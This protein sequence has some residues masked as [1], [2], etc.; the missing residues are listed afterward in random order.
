[1][2]TNATSQAQTEAS[3]SQVLA[4]R[5][6]HILKLNTQNVKLQEE[7]DNLVNELE[8]LKFRAG[9]RLGLA[10]KLGGEL[11]SKLEK[12]S[13][14]RDQYKKG[15]S[16]LQA[17]VTALK[18]QI[19]ERDEAIE[20]FTQEGLKLSKQELAQ[21]NII[22]KLRVREKEVE[23]AMAAVKGEL[24][25]SRKEASELKRALDNKNESERQNIGKRGLHGMDG[26]FEINWRNAR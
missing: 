16:D 10:E 12:S 21:S 17:E 23:T 1:M 5:E 11:S 7:N 20:Q 22:K 13:N 8:K 18:N 2:D 19:K 9:E 3:A 14:E 15:C 4:A 6:A 24:E 26:G 25:K